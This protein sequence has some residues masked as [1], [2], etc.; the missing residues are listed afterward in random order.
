MWIEK[1]DTLQKEFT[2]KNFTQAFS[3]MTLVAFAAEKI[4]HHPEWTNVYNRVSIKLS[5][6][7]AGNIVTQKDRDLANKIDEISQVYN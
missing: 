1:N 5:T 2:F 3:F 7:D 6:H 4:N